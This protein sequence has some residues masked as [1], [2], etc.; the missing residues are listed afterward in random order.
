M[1]RQ[2]TQS[3]NEWHSLSSL[4]TALSLLFFCICLLGCQATAP[5]GAEN[6]QWQKFSEKRPQTPSVQSNLPLVVH[7]NRADQIVTIRNGSTLPQ[8]YLLAYS[9]ASDLKAVLMMQAVRNTQ[10]RTAL[11][12]EG[13]VAINDQIVAASDVEREKFLKKF[14]Q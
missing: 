9:P 13:T 11:I 8:D 2:P 5:V 4:L 12:L 1:T 3:L 14:P 10:L 7:V 6:P